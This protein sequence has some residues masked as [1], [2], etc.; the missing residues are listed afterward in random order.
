MNVQYKYILRLNEFIMAAYNPIVVGIN[1]VRINGQLKM[2]SNS[3]VIVINKNGK[4]NRY[5]CYD[6]KNTDIRKI[7]IDTSKQILICTDFISDNYICSDVNTT[8]K[9]NTKL[10]QIPNASYAD[11]L[12]V[13][14]E[15][16]ND[17][18]NYVKE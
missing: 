8:M 1:A 2:I 6:K 11:V 5:Y 3:T 10:A 9:L 15:T 12:N 7:N 13:V 18:C 16:I 4:I 14:D 17:I